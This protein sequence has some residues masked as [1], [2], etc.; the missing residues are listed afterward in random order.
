MGCFERRSRRMEKEVCQQMTDDLDNLKRIIYY[1]RQMD[2]ELIAVTE[3]LDES[4]D[5]RCDSHS[6]IWDA[7]YHEQCPLCAEEE[8]GEMTIEEEGRAENLYLDKINAKD[9]NRKIT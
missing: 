8:A 9:A 2:A 1:I 3:R 5:A 7:D 6:R 4:E